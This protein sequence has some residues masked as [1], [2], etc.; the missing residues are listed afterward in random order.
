MVN[1]AER[2]LT[3]AQCTSAIQLQGSAPA[4]TA[5]PSCWMMV[6]SRPSCLPRQ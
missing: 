1:A 4:R 2:L 6:P 3:T 5:I